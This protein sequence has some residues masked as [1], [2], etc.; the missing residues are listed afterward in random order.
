MKTFHSLFV[1]IASCN[2]LFGQDTENDLIEQRV[3]VVLSK[4]DGQ[5]TSQAYRRLFEAAGPEGL[6]ELKQSHHDSIAIQAAWEEVTLTAPET[7]PR[8]ARPDAESLLRFFGFLEGRARVEIPEWW[9]TVVLDSRR[10]RKG[11]HILLRLPRSGDAKLE[12]PYHIAGPNFVRAPHDTTI[13]DAGRVTLRTGEDSIEI[14]DELIDRS[15][16]GKLLKNFSALFT[17]EKCYVAIH[18]SWGHPYT[19]ACLDQS[20]GAIVWTTNVWATFWG[21][22]SGRSRA[23]VFVTLQGERVVVLGASSTGIHVE[24]FDAKDGTNQFRFSSSY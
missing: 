1:V 23:W 9:T 15:D 10:Y 8:V 7:V 13:L 2:C 11:N 24:A 14:P 19:L 20:T 5:T 16:S 22:G 6:A 18:N 3:N 4:S 12:D 17:N 21:L